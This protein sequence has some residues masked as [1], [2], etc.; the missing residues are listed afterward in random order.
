MFLKLKNLGWHC[1]PLIPATKKPIEKLDRLGGFTGIHHDG[2]PDEICKEWD[3]KYNLKNCGLGLITGKSSN[4]SVLDLDTQSQDIL[5]VIPHS[6]L[7]K[8]GKNLGSYFFQHLEDC[9]SKILFGARELD[10]SVEF[11]NHNMLVVLPPTLHPSTRKPFEWIGEI[12]SLNGYSP[13]KLPTLSKNDLY[14]IKQHYI[15]KYGDAEGDTD[16][17]FLGSISPAVELD[18]VYQAVRENGRLRCAHGSQDRLKKMAAKLLAEHMPIEEAVKELVRYD[19]NH[20]EGLSYFQDKGRGKDSS[21]ADPYENALRFYTSMLSTVNRQRLRRGED[22]LSVV[23]ASTPKDAE[24]K[25][26]IKAPKKEEQKTLPEITGVMKTFVDYLNRYSI[27]ENTEVYLGAS[28][29]WLSML[30]ASR[31]AVKTKAFTTP[32]NLMVWGVMPSG[33]GKDSP[34]TLLQE[35]LYPHGVLGAGSYKSAPSLIMNLKNIFK[36]KKGKGDPEL[37]RKA[38]RENLMLMDECSTLFRIMAKGEGYQQDMVETLNTL[39]SKSSGFFA[40]DQSVERGIRYGAAYNPYFT[41]MGF[42]TFNHFENITGGKIVGNG[43]FERSLVFIKTKKSRF[44]KNPFKDD[45]A[46]KKLKDFTDAHFKTPIN[47]VDYGEY[48]PPEKEITT[49]V[50]YT[51]FPIKEDAEKFLHDYREK[52]Y[53]KDAEEIDVAFFNRFGELATKVSMLHSM[54]DGRSEI[55]VSDVEWA[56]QLVEWCYY[57][58]R[59]VFVKIQNVEDVYSQAVS[60]IQEK[61]EKKKITEISRKELLASTRFEPRNGH[62]SKFLNE[63]IEM[64]LIAVQEKD[65]KQWISVVYK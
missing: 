32:A 43:F 10:D 19:A 7:I 13:D 2:I 60:K 37:I 64:G 53:E 6:P 3:K 4:V 18:G 1:I 57:N 21:G 63:L 42:T 47:L 29:A 5:E 61:L 55:E 30:A 26:E 22:A 17:A 24:I 31:F 11:L 33:V 35:L 54:S 34:Q 23:R 9:E 48:V 28:L 12:K 51:E 58:A 38:Q 25:T 16:G 27:S 40:G 14:A 50:A 39:F 62:R 41:L 46:F 36:E 56:V 65:K 20:H 59:K 52:M 8:K 44:N 49:E 45:E 15:R